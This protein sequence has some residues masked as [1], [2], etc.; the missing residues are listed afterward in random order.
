MKLQKMTKAWFPYPDDPEESEFEIKHLRSGEISEITSKSYTQKFE[1]KENEEGDIEGTPFFEVNS[2]EEKEQ[3]IVKVV[4][5][6]RNVFDVEG[7][8]L[9]CN[10][11][12]K[13]RL[14][15]ELSEEDFI[16]FSKFIKTCREKL[17]EQFKEQDEKE[18]KN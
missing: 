3:T 4:T 7:E 18:I 1:M 2:K 14:C 10:K 9:E 11:K 8:K 15:R 6:W 16:S 13:L 12:N 17:A 5:N